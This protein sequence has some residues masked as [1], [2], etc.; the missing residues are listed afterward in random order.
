MQRNQ[1]Q[2]EYNYVLTLLFLIFF[3]WCN[4]SIYNIYMT[5]ISVSPFYTLAF[6]EDLLNLAATSYEL[7]RHN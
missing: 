7:F 2:S 5:D 4:I 1:S 3:G 6:F